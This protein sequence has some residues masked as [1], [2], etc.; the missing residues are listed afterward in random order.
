V[1]IHLT[2]C[3]HVTRNALEFERNAQMESWLNESVAAKKNHM[4]ECFCDS[5]SCVHQ[6]NESVAAKKQ[7][8][9]ECFCDSW[10]CVHQL[11]ES[12]GSKKIRNPRSDRDAS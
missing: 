6:L 1:Q 9:R 8:M 2:L 10:S 5:W 4:R 7:H 11:N 12:V 3:R